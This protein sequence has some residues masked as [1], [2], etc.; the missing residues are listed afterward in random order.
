MATVRLT[1]GAS[2]FVENKF[3][4]SCDFVLLTANNRVNKIE[5]SSLSELTQNN[6]KF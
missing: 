6:G 2:G 4:I 5:N 3:N 1:Q